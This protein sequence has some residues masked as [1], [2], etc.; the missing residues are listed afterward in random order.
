MIDKDIQYNICKHYKKFL[1]DRIKAIERITLW[2]LKINIFLIAMKHQLNIKTSADLAKWLIQQRIERGLVTGFGKTLQNIAKEFSNEKPL[3]G[4]T[5]RLIRN[6]TVYNFIIKSGPDHSV[7]VTAEIEL[8]L[9][10]TQKSEPGSESIFGIC[11]GNKEHLGNIVKSKLKNVKILI[12]KEFWEFISND[13]NCEQNI[14]DI[15]EDIGVNYHNK[16]GHSLASITEIKIKS[17]TKELERMYTDN[18]GTFWSNI[19]CDTY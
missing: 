7:P 13:P 12:G 2:D 1:D 18:E 17:I 4:M 9:L 16:D 10:E 11:Y 6:G 5:M 8:R 15:A 3:P 19:L 14:I